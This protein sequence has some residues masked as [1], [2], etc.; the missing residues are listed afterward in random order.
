M[1]QALYKVYQKL[2]TEHWWFI[3]RRALIHHLIK[4]YSN[5]RFIRM[6]DYVNEIKKSKK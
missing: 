2:E 5:I 4:K 1:E 6:I 3:G